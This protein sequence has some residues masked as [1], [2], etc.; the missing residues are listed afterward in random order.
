MTTPRQGGGEEAPPCPIVAPSQHAPRRGGPAG[1]SSRRRSPSRSGASGA[2]AGPWL[3]DRG[4]TYLSFSF[5]AP[6]EGDGYAS[7][8]AERGVRPWLTLGVDA[9]R[10][11]GDG[12]GQALAF[13]RTTLG[14]QSDASRQSF[15]LGFGAR[16]DGEGEILPALRAGLSWGRGFETRY[17]PGWVSTD[18][19]VTGYGSFATVGEEGLAL[20]LDTTLGVRPSERS[21]AQLQLFWSRSGADEAAVRL[22]PSYARRL[23][24]ETFGQVGLVIGTGAAPEIGVKLGLFT[25]F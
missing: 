2:A 14:P 16:L 17:G 23:R 10:A 13:A 20:K 6:Q 9:G 22:V 8:Y 19:S 24:G 1:S 18:A 5:E 21:V 11:A 12:E 7:L 4:S 15:E 25:E 3:R